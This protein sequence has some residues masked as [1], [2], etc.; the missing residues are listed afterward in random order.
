MLLPLHRVIIQLLVG[1]VIS[2]RLSTLFQFSPIPCLSAI[3]AVSFI[4]SPYLHLSCPLHHNTPAAGCQYLLF[5][6][7]ELFKLF[8]HHTSNQYVITLYS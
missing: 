5:H 7:P 4:H 1:Q 6:I 8:L 3:Y 2:D